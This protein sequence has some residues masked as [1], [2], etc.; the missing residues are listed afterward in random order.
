VKQDKLR[1][2]LVLLPWLMVASAAA[3]V[4]VSFFAYGAAESVRY[5]P[6]TPTLGGIIF[7]LPMLIAGLL[8]VRSVRNRTERPFFVQ[9]WRLA[10]GVLGLVMWI[11][12]GWAYVVQIGNASTYEGAFNQR[13]QR[14]EP[15]FS[16]T[17]FYYLTLG[18]ALLYPTGASIAAARFLY[19]DA[20]KPVSTTVAGPDPMGRLMAEMAEE[21]R[22]G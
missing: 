4:A 3:L 12:L 21:R 19:L 10:A 17:S 1:R 6:L 16:E 8:I 5:N 7:S 14:W 13:T 22:T 20:I 9:R 15:N 18:M 2:N 11:A